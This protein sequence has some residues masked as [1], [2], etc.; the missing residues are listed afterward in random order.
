MD[1]ANESIVE[2]A[3]QF[4]VLPPIHYAIKRGAYGRPGLLEVTVNQQLNI[5]TSVGQLTE[6]LDQIEEPFRWASRR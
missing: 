5:V 1:A 2:A 4:D 6:S 3:F